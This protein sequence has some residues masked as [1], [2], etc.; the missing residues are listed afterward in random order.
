MKAS[1]GKIPLTAIVLTQD[2]ETNIARCLECLK[3]VDDVVIVDSG[4]TDATLKTA[5]DVRS[6]VRMFE[7]PFRD[8]GDQRNW[9]LGEHQS[10]A[11]LGSVR[12]RG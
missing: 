6:D 10:P 9:A 1:P 2:E 5:E 3:P 11:R 7:H 4:S 12:R 8:F